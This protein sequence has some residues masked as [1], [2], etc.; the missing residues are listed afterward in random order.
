MA[1]ITGLKF[2][3]PKGHRVPIS[4]EVSEA[5]ATRYANLEDIAWIL[6][7]EE[8]GSFVH[9]AIDDGDEDISSASP[10]VSTVS[11]LPASAVEQVIDKA[12]QTLYGWD[13]AKHSSVSCPW[14]P[15][16]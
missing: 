7:V 8:C 10:N 16:L 15:K 3:R 13:T 1:K 4:I 5:H 11:A 6:T 2:L 14:A 12:Y 9:V